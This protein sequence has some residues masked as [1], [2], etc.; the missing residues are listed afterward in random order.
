M[1]LVIVGPG[2]AGGSIARAAR[3]AEHEIAGVVSRTGDDRFGP[4]LAPDEPWPQVDLAL[5]CVRDDQIEPLAI[6]M[7]SQFADIP[8]VAH[9]SGFVPVTALKPLAF[10]GVSLGGFHPLQTLPD[11]ERGAAALAVSY[12]GIG[13]EEL[14]EDTLI[15]FAISL[16]LKPFALDDAV[17]PLYHAA[18]AAAANFVATAL[19]T[20]SDLYA[21]AAIEPGVAAPLVSRVAQNVFEVGG[22]ESLT[23][24]IARGDTETVIGHL[25]AAHQV[26]ES[27]GKQFRLMAEATALLAGRFS[28]V[29]DWK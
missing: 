21:A 1:R 17:R 26:S 22:R 13:G 11:P 29:K 15:H 9:V 27:V 6:S 3:A 28:E 23:G 4:P 8:V 14:A 18:S 16:D 25:V 10:P 7:A 12:V 2:R 20:A 24:P 19:A 5:I